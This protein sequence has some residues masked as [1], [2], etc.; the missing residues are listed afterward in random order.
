FIEGYATANERNA[1]TLAAD[2]ARAIATFYTDN[3][4]DAS[5]IMTEGTVLPFQP[6]SGVPATITIPYCDDSELQ[7]KRDA[8]RSQVEQDMRQ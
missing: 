2:R 1:E 5:R 4:I 7:P 6:K 3:G 8:V